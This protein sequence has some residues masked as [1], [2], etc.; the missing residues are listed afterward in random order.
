MNIREMEALRDFIKDL[1]PSQRF[2]ENTAVAWM[3]TALRGATLAEARR[4][5]AD[6]VNE[7]SAFIAAGELITR[8]RQNRQERLQRAVLPEPD[9][10]DPGEYVAELRRTRE[11][12]AAGMAV[13]EENALPSGPATAPPPELRELRARRAGVDPEVLEQRNA[14]NQHPCRWCGA[15]V[16]E[17]CV[18]ADGKPLRAAAAHHQRLVDAGLAEPGEDA[19]AVRARFAEV[20]AANGMLGDDAD[21]KGTHR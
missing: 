7:G 12:I 6:L 20:L 18:G 16:G 1:C 13:P 10:D 8:I 21:G 9:T 5:V 3:T 19:E 11:A 17:V 4:A 2:T 15:G 14:A